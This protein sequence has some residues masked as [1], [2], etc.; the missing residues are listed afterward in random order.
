MKKTC[1]TNYNLKF[2][3]QI[4]FSR[5]HNQGLWES[6]HMTPYEV[7]KHM[8]CI[9]SQDFNQHLRAIAS[10]I[11]EVATCKDIEQAYNQ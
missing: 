9:Q 1:V 5:L 10:R 6:S 8:M 4:L 11:G 2:M 3:E 7:I